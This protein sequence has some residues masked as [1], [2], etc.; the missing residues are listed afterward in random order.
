MHRDSYMYKWI[1]GQP[2]ASDLAGRTL[3]SVRTPQW[4]SG[5]RHCP[6]AITFRASSGYGRW[7]LKP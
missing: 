6:V 2:I 4:R 5:G 3:A 1:V 7:H